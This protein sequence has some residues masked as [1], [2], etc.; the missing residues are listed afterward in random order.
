MKKVWL[1]VS[2]EKFLGGKMVWLSA[3]KVWL[4]GG[5]ENDSSVISLVKESGLITTSYLNEGDLE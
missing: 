3:E 5:G 4:S 1:F 2:V